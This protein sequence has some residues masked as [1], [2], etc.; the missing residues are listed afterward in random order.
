MWHHAEEAGY[1]ENI[2]DLYST[3]VGKEL[4]IFMSSHY[5]ANEARKFQRG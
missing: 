1:K 5:I 3:W 2:I 4:D